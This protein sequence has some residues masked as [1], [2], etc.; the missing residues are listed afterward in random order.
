MHVEAHLDIDAVAV[1]TAEEVNVLVRLTAPV[2]AR[3]AERSPAALVVV[4]DRS[5]SMSGDRLA[6]AREALTALV[7]R[8]DP[9]DRFGVVVFDDRV[10]VVV[11]AGAV[12]DKRALKAAIAG[13]A[14]RGSTDLSAGYL[15]GLQEARRVARGDVA[16]VLLVSDGHANAGVTDPDLLG[17]IARQACA[18][19]VSTTTLGMGL[20]YDEAVLSA[21]AR[22]GV[23][24]ELFAEGADTAVALVAREVDGLLGQSVQAASLL[25]RMDPAVAAVRVANDLPT[26]VVESGVLVELGAFLSGESRTVVLGFAVPGMAALGLARIAE[27]ELRFVQL[28][29]LVEHVVTVPVHVNVV[30]SDVVAARVPDPVVRSEVVFQEAQRA[31]REA[32]RH[33]REGR[34][35]EALRVLGVARSAVAAPMPA[36]MPAQAQ[37]LSTEAATLEAMIAEATR[38]SVSRASKLMSSDAARKSR[39]RGRPER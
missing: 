7:D 5:G 34:T 21:I 30:P 27:L 35:D 16:R 3:D 20:G 33:L 19:G 8:L 9:R 24:A 28:P 2:L 38:G 26:H 31:K 1:E 37:D 29:E 15:R 23:G 11:P 18:A 32:S 39:T 17:S 25:V 6:A 36:V 22:E 4:L 12:V 10:D 13:V 14:A